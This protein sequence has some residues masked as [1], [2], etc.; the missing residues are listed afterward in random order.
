MKSRPNGAAGSA[1]V[2][3]KDRAAFARRIGLRIVS[4]DALHI[5][6]RKQRSGFAY[7]SG[8]GRAITDARLL[9]RLK[10]LAV[11]PAYTQVRLAQ[12]PRAHLQAIGRDAAGRL[13]YRYHPDWTI[14]REAH[15]AKHLGQLLDALPRVRRGLT[16]HLASRTP[17]REM[18]LAAVVE[19]VAQT[20]IRAGREIYARTYGTR[21]AA[22][23]LKSDIALRG[24]NLA[25]EF[26]AK[27]GK[28][29]QK[30]IEGGRLA[31]AVR[32][33]RKLPGRRLFQ[34]LDEDGGVRAVRARDVNDFLVELSGA[35]VTLKDFRTLCACVTTLE[36]VLRAPLAT[37]SRQR[38]RQL[39]EAVKVA[40]A[41]LGNTPSMCRKSY[42]RAVLDALED[43][44]AA[45]KLA[46]AQNGSRRPKPEKILSA[47]L[48]APEAIL[49]ASMPAAVSQSSQPHHELAER[50]CCGT[51]R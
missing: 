8:Q 16:K 25:L 46:A 24:G 50:A 36:A 14:I 44:Q 4:P 10:S 12:D 22:T 27:G 43:Q 47:L 5:R 21:G 6:R 51:G 1:S 13:Q 42:V 20:S 35:A 7:Y 15:K 40:S 33:L 26:T 11:P 9:R 29:F 2:E 17:T 31:A 39:H 32:R 49:T 19:M 48:Q 37:N 28:R 23:L 3:A 34:Y 41:E 30:E 18:A 45:A 38:S